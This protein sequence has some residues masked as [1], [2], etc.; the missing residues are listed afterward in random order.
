MDSTVK[1]FTIDGVTPSVATVIDGTYTINRPILMITDGEPTSLA[2]SYLE[3]I[4]SAD[5]QKILSDKGFVP[6]A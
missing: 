3:F 4:P 1:A 2:A 6:V 5:G